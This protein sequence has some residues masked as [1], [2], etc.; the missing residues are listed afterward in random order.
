[1]DQD[2]RRHR[3]FKR[4]LKKAGNKHRRRDLKDQLRAQPEEAHWH[5][6]NLGRYQSAPLNAYDKDATRR[7]DEEE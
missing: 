1:M 4:E 5:E 2:K 6:E 7:R 3:Q